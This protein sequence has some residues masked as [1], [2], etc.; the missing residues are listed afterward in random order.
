MNQETIVKCLDLEGWNKITIADDVTR[1]CVVYRRG[2]KAIVGFY[3]TRKLLD[4]LVN[5]EAWKMGYSVGSKKY[6]AHAGFV[7]E[8]LTL[9]Q[10]IFEATSDANYIEVHGFS[11]GGTHAILLTRDT[12]YN[13]PH[14]ETFTVT[15][16]APRVYSWESAKEF[17]RAKETAGMPVIQHRFYGDPVPRV[18]FKIMG[19]GDCGLISW[20]GKKEL[21]LDISCHSMDA[22]HYGG[23]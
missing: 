21:P 2:E 13:R 22:R 3:Q 11:Q 16:G 23:V 6:K 10:N 9:R 8:Y 17:D 15:Y 4:W 18:P 12:W 14:L 7:S 1:K 5:F 19:Y 20:H